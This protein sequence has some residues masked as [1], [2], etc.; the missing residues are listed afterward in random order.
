MK[1]LCSGNC[2]ADT[3]LYLLMHAVLY[4]GCTVLLCTLMHALLYRLYSTV[5][6]TYACSSVSAA[7]YC[8]MYSCMHSCI[9]C[10]LLYSLYSRTV[11]LNCKHTNKIGYDNRT[12]KLHVHS[13]DRVY[14]YTLMT[15]R[16]CTDV[17]TIITIIL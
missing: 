7:L 3:K 2:S 15:G 11:S 8:C 17:R 16:T 5:V 12:I 13:D 1:I 9:G 14:T 6:R 4:I 10:T